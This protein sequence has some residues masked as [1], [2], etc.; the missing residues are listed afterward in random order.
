MPVRDPDLRQ[1]AGNRAIATLMRQPA[2]DQG[3]GPAGPY[4]AIRAFLA[5][6][7]PRPGKEE[8]A[9]ELLEQ[10]AAEKEMKRSAELMLLLTQIMNMRHEMKKAV[11][12]NLRA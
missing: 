9:Q 3:P 10:L 7:R 1:L 12:A 11:I 5:R 4:E 8:L 6:Q 2:S